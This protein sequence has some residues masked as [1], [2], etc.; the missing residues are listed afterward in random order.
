[1]FGKDQILFG[2]KQQTVFAVHDMAH[3][4]DGIT[5]AFKAHPAAAVRKAWIPGNVII[6]TLVAINMHIGPATLEQGKFRKVDCGF[7]FDKDLARMISQS[8]I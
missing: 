4:I 6:N 3:F 2:G 5:P 8:A 7:R 1:M